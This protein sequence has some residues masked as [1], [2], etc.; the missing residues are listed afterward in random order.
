[1]AWP[2]RL[3][4]VALLGLLS[5]LSVVVAGVSHHAHAAADATLTVTDCSG[6]TGPGRIG[7]VIS[8]ASAG[9]TIT[10][11]CSGTIPIT[12]TL[13][14][15][16]NNLTLD[17]SGQTVTLD[18]GSST[19]VLSVNSGV[20]FTLNALT[21]AN[22][23]NT[24]TSGGGLANNGGTV[25]ITNSTFT[26]NIANG[27]GGGLANNGGTVTITNST[28]TNNFATGSGGGLLNSGGTVTITNSTF[29]KNG[30]AGSSG[31]LL[32]SGGTVTITNSTFANNSSNGT[33][34]GLSNG[35]T[36]TITN[37][38][39]A[40]NSSSAAGGG[41]SNGGTV[42]IT[43]STF[44]NNHASNTGGGLLNSGTVTITNSTFANNSAVEGGGN[45]SGTLTDQGYNLSS[46]TSCGFTASTSLQNT[47]PKLDPSGL[48]NNG[49][50]TQTIALEP[51][52]P[53]VDKIPV[54]SSCPATDQ[55]GVSRPQGPA[56]DIGAFEMTA[57]DGLTVMIHV[58]NS[59]QLSTGLQTS[60]NTKLQAAL[61]S[62]KA[63]KA[64]A[65]CGQ[66]DGFSN[67]VQAQSGKGLTTTQATQLINE[68]TVI[69][70]RL[71]C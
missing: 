52:S 43:N 4:L 17:G 24:V 32:N 53:A 45:C 9:D 36:V 30:S 64:S 21:I 54:G 68:A 40:N 41:L 14:I 42:T 49:G 47:D 23:R 12:S 34:G 22:G 10:F 60:L 65:A 39:F 58:V 33:G 5:A 59:F 69:T 48:Q 3:L 18:G 2:S 29:A 28:F 31:G 19:Q 25:T 35:G 20:T 27:I 11:S 37:S 51:D 26:N 16:T 13:S 1:M 55:R 63:G 38:T 66:L 7:T 46:D 67:A 15:S 44:A 57:A 8:S 70:T 71:G 61:A 62:V 50:P 6:E 56:C